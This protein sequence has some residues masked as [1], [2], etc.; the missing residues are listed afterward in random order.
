MPDDMEPGVS[1]IEGLG[2]VDW[3]GM[4][5]EL[6]E[7]MGDDDESGTESD[8]SLTSNNS[9]GSRRSSSR[10]HKRR[11]DEATDEDDSEEESTM[12]K[13][14][15]IANSRTTSLKTVKTPT[16]ASESSLPTPGVTGD[17]N[18]EVDQVAALESDHSFEEDLE[19]EMEAAF[20]QE[21]AD[22]GAASGAE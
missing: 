21:L 15:R 6:A 4:D 7:F 1:P 5:D 17:E 12:V 22:A 8:G 19:A 10:G 11:F 3:G 18:D 20:E 14:Q 9:R 16:S 2:D 13:K